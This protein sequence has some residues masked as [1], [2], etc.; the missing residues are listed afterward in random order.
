MHCLPQDILLYS[1]PRV[2]QL[3]ALPPIVSSPR[4]QTSEPGHTHQGE[5]ESSSHAVSRRSRDQPLPPTSSGK[6]LLLE[7]RV[8]ALEQANRA[9]LEELV[10]VQADA[11]ARETHQQEEVRNSRQEVE[12][13]RETVDSNAGVLEGLERRVFENER[14]IERGRGT[15]DLLVES[16][17]ETERGVHESQA[18]L[19]LRLKKEEAEG[20]MEQVRGD[21]YRLEQKCLQF[22]EGIGRD[23]GG[24]LEEVRRLRSGLEVQSVGMESAVS[25]IRQHLKRL[26]VEHDSMVRRR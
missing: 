18:G 12:R 10:R 22:Q 4:Q 11:K 20:R 26:E 21:L 14:S 7:S 13:L 8:S 15:V 19:L 17:R 2:S 5:P 24:L 25:G 23:C 6:L 1:L 9:L 3:P 16:T